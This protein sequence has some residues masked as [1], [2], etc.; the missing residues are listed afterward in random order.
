[1]GEAVNVKLCVGV[2]EGVGELLKLCVGLAEGV[3]ERVG[4]VLGVGLK[5]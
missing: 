1:M 2:N 4:D 3:M 5:V